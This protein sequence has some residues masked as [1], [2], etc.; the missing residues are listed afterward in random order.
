MS[1]YPWNEKSNTFTCFSSHCNPY[2]Y[3]W[4]FALMKCVLSLSHR[5]AVPER[6]FS[7]NKIMLKSHGYTID[8]DTI[9]ALI[10]VKD[11]IGKEDES[12]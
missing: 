11:S 3:P 2:K 9:V 10:L 6:G 5:N 12:Y 1:E 7:M 8:N 4:L